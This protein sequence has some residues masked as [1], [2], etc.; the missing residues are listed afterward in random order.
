MTKEALEAERQEALD[1]IA[2]REAEKDENEEGVISEDVAVEIIGG[3][4][5]A[6]MPAY[7]SYERRYATAE[8]VETIYSYVKSV[9]KQLRYDESILDIIK[10][11]ASEY[12]GGKK[13]LDDAAA[14]AESRI[15]IKLGEQM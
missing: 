15:N 2:K 5:I 12:F 13:S 11:E 7:P 6:K 3:N 9:K 8:D 1:E 4:G 14:H 10:E